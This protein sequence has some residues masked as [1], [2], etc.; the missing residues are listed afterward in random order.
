MQNVT[1]AYYLEK[2][3]LCLVYVELAGRQ[4]EAAGMKDKADHYRK[5]YLRY[6]QMNNTYDE[7]AGVASVDD[8][9]Y[10]GKIERG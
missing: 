3:T 1:N 2:L 5:E 6:S 9:V 4:M 8:G 10:S 7:D